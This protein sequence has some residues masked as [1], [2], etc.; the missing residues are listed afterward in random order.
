MK[1]RISWSH[2]MSK[3]KSPFGLRLPTELR[4]E[5]VARAHANGRSLNREICFILGQ[6]VSVDLEEPRKPNSHLAREI[7]RNSKGE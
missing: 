7:L 4:A 1:L 5:V 6:A 3:P 2:S